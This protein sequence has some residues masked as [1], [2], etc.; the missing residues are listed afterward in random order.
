MRRILRV[1]NPGTGSGILGAPMR[2][3]PHSDG[4]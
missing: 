3:D 1:R 4:A 2:H